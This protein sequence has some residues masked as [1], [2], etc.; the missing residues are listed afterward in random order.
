MKTVN[1]VSKLTGVSVRTLHYYDSIGLLSPSSVTDAGYRLYDD[2]ALL[3][4]QNILLFR[5][6][7]F[8]LK[9]IKGILDAPGFDRGKAL[10]QQIKLLELQK[11]HIANL[12][13]FA[14]GI[15]STGATNMDF[16]AFD[17]SKIDDYAAQAK[18]Q[19]G[20]TD[21]YKEYEKK[22]ENRTESE[23]DRINAGLMEIFTRFG[24]I[25]EVSPESAEAQSLVKELKEYIT[26]H[27]YTCTDEI[28]LGLSSMYSGG[29]SMTE[30]IDA[31]GGKGTGEFSA[32]AIEVYCNKQ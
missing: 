30:N 25:K 24:K 5:E 22:A 3:R 28:L 32:R 29:G 9:E 8:S 21:A 23:Q 16:K 27:F 6:L 4:L 18:L 31:A 10:E 14:R 7:Q 19:W 12:I 13:T 17:K 20:N 2:D 26:E 11:E 1:V 15:K